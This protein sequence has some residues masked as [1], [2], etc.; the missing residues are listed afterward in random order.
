MKGGDDIKKINKKDILIII[1]TLFLGFSLRYLINNYSNLKNSVSSEIYSMKVSNF[2]E[3][4]FDEV[5]DSIELLDVNEVIYVGSNNCI[6]CRNNI[7]KIKKIKKA[8]VNK[9]FTFKYLNTERMED[10][11]K[12]TF[13]SILGI[14]T[15]P[16][17][18]VINS[19]N[20]TYESFNSESISE[21]N[22]YENFERLIKAEEW[23]EWIKD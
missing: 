15:I 8:S 19:K 16:A 22:Y 14:E 5:K 1:A 13:S 2:D 7:N 4:S 21:K 23:D 6:Y 12:K 3:T 20:N 18:I 17:I 9:D 11:D 10:Y